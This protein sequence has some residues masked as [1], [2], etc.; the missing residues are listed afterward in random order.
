MQ[1][2]GPD[3]SAR[4]RRTR[5]RPGRHARRRSRP[6]DAAPGRRPRRRPPLRA[7]RSV[8]GGLL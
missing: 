8:R 2:R 4:G 3:S 5:P 7:W 6:D 1:P